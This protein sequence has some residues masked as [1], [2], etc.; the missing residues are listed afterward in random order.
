MP[1]QNSCDDGEVSDLLSE[2]KGKYQPDSHLT[3]E[4]FW[5][6]VENKHHVGSLISIVQMFYHIGYVR[7]ILNTINDPVDIAFQLGILF[8][9]VSCRQS[10]CRNQFR[11]IQKAPGM[12]LNSDA[13]EA[14]QG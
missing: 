2:F 1:S 14:I 12:A 6:G 5:R 13:L 10:S 9:C 11:D 4:C 7:T 3:A 8:V